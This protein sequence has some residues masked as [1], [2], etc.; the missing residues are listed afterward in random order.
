MLRPLVCEKLSS[1]TRSTKMVTGSRRKF[2]KWI[3]NSLSKT[4]T[5]VEQT[6]LDGNRLP[7]KK[8]SSGAYSIVEL[9]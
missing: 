3:N 7:Q 1:G 5:R 6:P 9:V 2:F 8:N 4:N